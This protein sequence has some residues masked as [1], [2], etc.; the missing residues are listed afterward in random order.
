[1]SLAPVAGIATR[2]PDPGANFY[3][4]GLWCVSR[5]FGVFILH[6][7]LVQNEKPQRVG[8]GISEPILVPICTDPLV[9]FPACLWAPLLVPIGPKIFYSVV[10][11]YSLLLELSSLSSPHIKMAPT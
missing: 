2:A 10:C 9:R 8:A 5:H 6:Q 11:I 3:A 4:P 1:M 7:R